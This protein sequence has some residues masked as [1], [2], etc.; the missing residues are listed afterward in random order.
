MEENL[1][2]KVKNNLRHIRMTE[3]EEEPKEFAD[4]LKVKLK[5]YYVW[6][7]GAALPSSK[8]IFKIAKILNKK[9]DEIW[10]L[11]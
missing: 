2:I 5:T 3:Y 1:E 11:E 8:K 4:R 9:V 6:E 7:S 10:W